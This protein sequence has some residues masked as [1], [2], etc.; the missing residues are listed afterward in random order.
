MRNTW[1]ALY[2]T[3]KLD[4]SWCTFL[5][6]YYQSSL[7]I[8]QKTTMNREFLN[9]FNYIINVLR[10]VNRIWENTVLRMPS[11]EGIMLPLEKGAP[12][13]TRQSPAEDR[14]TPCFL[15]TIIFRFFL[16][17][18]LLP[19]DL[20]LISSN[21]LFLKFPNTLNNLSP[22]K[23]TTKHY[24]LL[25]P[26]RFLELT[27]KH[28]LFQKLGEMKSCKLYLRMFPI[29]SLKA[30]LVNV[31]KLTFH[32]SVGPGEGS[33]QAGASSY[34]LPTLCTEPT[35]GSEIFKITKQEDICTA[36]NI[37]IYLHKW[38]QNWCSSP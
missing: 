17:F 30:G 14:T 8:L 13:C 11:W 37:C 26:V 19:W 22:S 9:S 20:L 21:C 12:G 5:Q 18:L 25:Y 6:I 31:Y 34:P 29:V 10:A 28:I 1:C 23:G 36:R 32:S 24:T 35:P 4:G 15:I 3:F 2:I 7:E 16:N 38:R 27:N 33:P